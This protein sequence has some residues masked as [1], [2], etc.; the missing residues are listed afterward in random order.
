MTP[1]IQFPQKHFSVIEKLLF[2]QFKDSREDFGAENVCIL[3]CVC[4]GSQSLRC[5]E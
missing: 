4:A 3:A 5:L 2:R 1:Y